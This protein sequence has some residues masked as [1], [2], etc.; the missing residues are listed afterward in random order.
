M[1]PGPAPTDILCWATLFLCTICYISAVST[2]CDHG[3]SILILTICLYRVII[4]T[5]PTTIWELHRHKGFCDI[6]IW[7]YCI[8][9]SINNRRIC[10]CFPWN[11]N[12]SPATPEPENSCP[13]RWY[14]SRPHLWDLEGV[15][16]IV[17]FTPWQLRRRS[18]YLIHW[19]TP[20]TPTT[21]PIVPTY[22][23]QQKFQIHDTEVW[24]NPLYMYHRHFKSLY[25]CQ[26]MIW[27]LCIF[28]SPSCSFSCLHLD[29]HPMLNHLP[30][31]VHLNSPLNQPH[32]QHHCQ[33]MSPQ[34]YLI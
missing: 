5:Q 11:C 24:M 6:T 23:L 19:P 2:T 34:P 30:I 31:L 12:P 1:V 33:K 22:K 14:R 18:R 27:F 20:S 26:K 3:Q 28:R 8:N 32:S 13:G 4:Y 15:I 10:I 25:C 7:K 17:G 16:Y 29:V 9:L 21:C